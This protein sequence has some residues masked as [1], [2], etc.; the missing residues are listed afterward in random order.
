[1]IDTITNTY[2]GDLTHAGDFMSRM[3]TDQGQ[4][5]QPTYSVGIDPT[6]VVAAAGAAPGDM[7][8][9]GAVAPEMPAGEGGAPV[10]PAAAA[11]L[12]G[13]GFVI[14]IAGRTPFGT[15]AQLLDETLI[16]NLQN[17]SKDKIPSGKPF[18]VE[19]AQIVKIA[20]L[21]ADPAHLQKIQS[22]YD[23]AVRAKETGQ[24]TASAA[25]MTNFGGGGEEGMDGFRGGYNGGGYAGG[26]FG[27]AAPAAAGAADPAAAAQFAFKDRQFPDE[28]I[29]E[30]NDFIVAVVISLDP[31]PKPPADPNAAPANG[32]A[33]AAPAE[34]G[35]APAAP[36]TSEPAAAPAAQPAASAQ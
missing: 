31:P 30:D 6:K 20:S 18:A 22:D 16:K 9:G 29:R 35:A 4:V 3:Q 15:P 25:S 14:R 11:G 36:A 24:F 23:N 1:M 34:G 32:A 21:G 8:G 28:D 26:G 5:P 2:Y 17:L 13:R 10:D 33:P 19:R 12:T 7:G 27:G